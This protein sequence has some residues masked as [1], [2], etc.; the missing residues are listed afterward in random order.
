MSTVW[1]D[2]KGCAKQYSCTLAIYL[3]TVLLSSYVII[4]DSAIN[5][6]VQ[7]KNFIDGLNETENSHMKEQMELI[8]KLESN[9]TSNIGILPSASK[10]ASI[11]FL[12]QCIHIINNKDRLNGL[13]GST[14][15]QI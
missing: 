8:G 9:V 3:M 13:K 7:G 5:A 14:H 1:E 15:M 12:D 4:M 2:T 10:Y 11:K 6:P